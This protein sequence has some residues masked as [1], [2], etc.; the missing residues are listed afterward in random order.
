MSDVTG[1]IGNMNVWV[2]RF[3]IVVSS[4]LAYRHM[5]SYKSISASIILGGLT[6]IVVGI[7]IDMFAWHLLVSRSGPYRLWSNF[8]LFSQV[9]S[10]I[11]CVVLVYGLYLTVIRRK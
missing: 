4:Y 10:M 8:M 1:L 6:L 7:V 9:I 3:C 5:R 2:T 11:G